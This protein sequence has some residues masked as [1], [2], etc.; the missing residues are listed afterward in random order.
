MLC[1]IKYVVLR[2]IIFPITWAFLRTCSLFT[3]AAAGHTQER[4]F[5][6]T[7]MSGR[8]W[9]R[10]RCAPIPLVSAGVATRYFPHCKSQ[11]L[12]PVP[13][14]LWL[15]IG[16]RVVLH[17]QFDPGFRADSHIRISDEALRVTYREHPH[18]DEVTLRGEVYFPNLLFE[19]TQVRH[20]R[21]TF[22]SLSLSLCLFGPHLCVKEVTPGCSLPQPAL[23]ENT[24]VLMACPQVSY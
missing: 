19:K 4:M 17:V 23:L 1:V 8:A 12:F 9:L 5:H 10:F 22:L 7:C 20:C 2:L 6:C 21:V 15:G 16:E 18:V 11:D 24:G 14:E 3:G 13:Q